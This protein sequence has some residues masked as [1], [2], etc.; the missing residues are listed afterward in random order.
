MKLWEKR[1]RK[2]SSR[3]K[4]CMQTN[5]KTACKQEGQ[6]V[7]RLSTGEFGTIKGGKEERNKPESK[8]A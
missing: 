1:A 3:T 8:Q 4:E 7:S 2:H 6:E 5:C